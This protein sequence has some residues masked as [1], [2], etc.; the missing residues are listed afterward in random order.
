M[1]E[2]LAALLL[3]AAPPDSVVGRYSMNDGPDVASE[4]VLGADGRFTYAIIAGAAD[5]HASGKWERD[6]DVVRLTTEPKPVPPAFT[7]GPVSRTTEEPFLVV[8]RGPSGGAIAGVDFRVGM[9]DGSRVEGYTQE[10]GWTIRDGE[11]KGKP[12]WVELALDMFNLV[13]PRFPVNADQGNLF[14]F[15]LTPNDIGVMDFQREAFRITPAGLAQSF[16]PETA[17]WIK[18]SK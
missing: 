16:G 9:A 2:L 14:T 8:V 12:V 18:A 6:G 13:S 4:L 7:P 3:F 1:R 11:P 17:E 10:Q 15:T 5:Y